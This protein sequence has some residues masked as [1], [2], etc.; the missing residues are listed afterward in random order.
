[1]VVFGADLS[2]NR[3]MKSAR[4]TRGAVVVLSMLLL[5]AAPPVFAQ[6][7]P[8]SSSTNYS[9][10]QVFMGSGS[11]L[12]SCSAS[13]CSRQSAGDIA[14]GHAAGNAFQAIAGSQTNREPY[15]AF[16]TSGGNTDLGILSTAGTATATATFAVKTYLAHGYTVVLAS[17]PPKTS[18]A[19][20]HTFAAPSS[21]TAA[22]SPGTQEQFG[23]NLVNNTTGCGS[24]VNMGANP[25]Q[26]PDNT[27][28]YG[29][30]AAGYNTCGLFKYVKGDT[31]AS[32]T[33]STGQTDYTI[34]F[35][36]N[37]TPV[38][39]DGQYQFDGDLV[40]ISTY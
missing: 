33:R 40:A 37:I 26:V 17:D 25:V 13:Y 12:N 29:S 22:A 7:Q 35:I 21:P 28:S 10:D 18:G 11:Q 34:S 38:T 8:E 23:I 39:P 27:F 14:A 5:F 31:V 30:V 32:S 1:V 36:Y 24:P 19:F 15:I 6:T 20:S 2:E 4:R 16:S 9:V 3:D